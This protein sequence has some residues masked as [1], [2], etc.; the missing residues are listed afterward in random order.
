MV[1]YLKYFVPSVSFWSY[2]LITIALTLGVGT[3]VSRLTAPGYTA[4][5]GTTVYDTRGA[6]RCDGQEDAAVCHVHK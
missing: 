2:T 4:P 6:S 5:A 1:I 3:I